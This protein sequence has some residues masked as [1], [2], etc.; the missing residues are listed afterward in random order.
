MLVMID[1]Y[2][3]FTFNVYQELGKM[4]PDI[5]V[6]KND[7]ITVEE[8]E[9]L[10]PEAL[11]IS[12]GPG[13]PDQAGV[14]LQ[15]IDY[16]KDKLPI[17]GICLGHQSIGQCFGGKIVKAFQPMHGKSTKI[18]L[19]VSAPIFYGLPDHLSVAR[20]HSLVIDRATCPSSLEIIAEDDRGEIMAVKHKQYPIYGVQFHPESVLAEMGNNMLYNFLHRI[21]GLQL[22]MDLDVPEEK[23][24]ALKPYLDKVMKQQRLTSDELEHC[25][26]I[27]E[28]N[29]A[30]KAQ[31]ASLISCIYLQKDLYKDLFQYFQTTD[32]QTIKKIFAQL[33]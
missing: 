10:Q 16:F 13:D 25:I 4:Y 7:Q 26:Q 19:D 30:S 12:P 21:V 31:I 8:I 5:Q 33:F 9:A 22:T 1:N 15:A 6:Y 3:S 23:R 24:T 18:Q 27:I 14:S 29:G 32:D 20:Y 28:N 2:D 11:I 17:L